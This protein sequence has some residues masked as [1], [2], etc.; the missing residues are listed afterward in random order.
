MLL[1]NKVSLLRQALDEANSYEEWKEIA[2][3]LDQVMDHNDNVD[4]NIE[5]RGWAELST[6][7]L[8][9]SFW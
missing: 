4:L 7:G 6:Y 9:P 1:T 5:P 2:L 8:L 3:E